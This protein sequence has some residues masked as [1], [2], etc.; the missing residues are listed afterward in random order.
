[1][2]VWEHLWWD[3]IGPKGINLHTFLLSPQS[4]ENAV[5]DAMLKSVLK[6][7]SHKTFNLSTAIYFEYT[8]RLDE[9]WKGRPS[10]N[11]VIF[12]LLG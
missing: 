6:I 11:D 7:Y 9:S 2:C 12:G 10:I 4:Q 3:E 1:M 5:L 8:A